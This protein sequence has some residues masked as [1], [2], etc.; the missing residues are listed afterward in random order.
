MHR[1]IST[2]IL[3]S[4]GGRFWIIV[5]S[6]FLNFAGFTV[7]I[8]VLPFAVARYVPTDQIAT[9]V[10]VILSAYALCS[11]LAA[12]FL[13]ALSDRFGRRPILIFSLCGSAIGFLVFGLGG[14][15]WVLLLGRVI[16]GLTA[17]SISAMYAYVADIIAPSERGA[18]FG[19]LGAAAGLGFMCG[20]AL[21]GLVGQ[22]SVSAPLYAAA[23][24]AVLNA[25]WV[26]LAVPESHPVASRPPRLN[27]GHLNPF[28]ALIMVLR[29]GQLRL[30][31]GVAFCFFVAATL[32][33]AN[34]SVL[35]KDLL[36]FDVSGVGAVL[37]GVGLI[38]IFSQGIVAPRLLS[39]YPERRV[40]TAGLA[41]NG[42]GFFMLA[43][44]P[45][46]PSIALMAAGMIVLTFGDGL[47]QPS[48]NA[49]ISK[50]CPLGQQGRVQG[51]NQAQQSIA[52]MFGPLVS[53]WLY[54]GLMSGPYLA[55]GAIVVVDAI[56]L[57]IAISRPVVVQPLDA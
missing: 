20:P 5:V 42:L 4:N 40:G 28:G 21:G 34:L 38:D 35:L 36:G 33:Q 7:I 48:L 56:I 2:L 27:W 44:L 47:A 32:M 13:G 53:A 39:R 24:L 45:L 6:A 3:P 49:L 12:P 43:A 50:A 55:G 26:F 18:A 19:L 31:F 52:R 10:S 9:Y 37:F 41:I 25:L 11:F 23:A 17:G 8:P 46:Y 22:L 14:A 51:A 30:L 1:Q 57:M 15:L 29:D 16:E 54:V